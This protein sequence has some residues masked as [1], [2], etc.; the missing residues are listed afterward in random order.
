MNPQYVI[1]TD[2]HVPDDPQNEVFEKSM[3]WVVDQIRAHDPLAVIHLGDT[4]RSMTSVSIPAL[5]AAVRWMREIAVLAP[6]FVVLA[7]NHD[8]WNVDRSITSL[9]MFEAFHIRV[10]KE[11][12]VASVG[13]ERVALLPYQHANDAVRQVLK[14]PTRFA[15]AHLPINDL[16]GIQEPLGFSPDDFMAGIRRTVFCGHYHW[17]MSR[18][19]E[20]DG[21]ETH[22]VSVGSLMATSWSDEQ[23]PEDVTRSPRGIVVVHQDGHHETI[24]NPH[25][26][27]YRTIR[28]EAGDEVLDLPEQDEDRTILRVYCPPEAVDSVR[29]RVDSLAYRRAEVMPTK[30][31][32]EVVRRAEI[33]QMSMRQAVEDYAERNCPEDLDKARLR[34]VGLYFLQEER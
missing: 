11:P 5:D 31:Q 23:A 2:I 25:S 21:V 6:E 17:P 18:W 26:P 34:Q 20:R 19:F 24:A 4:F 28:V 13:Q 27:I 30:R 22:F 29:K 12:T 1:L 10:V 8:Q 14:E 3:A 7:G 16:F 9:S 15:F 32:A 33:E